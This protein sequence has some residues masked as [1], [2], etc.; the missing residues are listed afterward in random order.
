MDLGKFV[1]ESKPTITQFRPPLSYE[2]AGKSFNFLM[3]DGFDYSLTVIDG[4][5][6]EWPES[7]TACPGAAH[8][9]SSGGEPDR[10]HA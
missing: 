7:A 2:L 10:D 5:T 1:K 3:D 9:T 4:N 8:T 6:V